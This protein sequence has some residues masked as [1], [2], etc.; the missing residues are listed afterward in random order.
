LF[1]SQNENQFL[2]AANDQSEPDVIKFSFYLIDASKGIFVTYLNSFSKQLDL[3]S[4]G[5]NDGKYFFH[6]SLCDDETIYNK[7]YSFD[8]AANELLEFIAIDDL[9][10]KKEHTHSNMQFDSFLAEMVEQTANDSL[11][12]NDV[13]DFFS[14][15]LTTL[16]NEFQILMLQQIYFLEK[17][18]ILFLAYAQMVLVIDVESKKLV[19]Q[20]KHNFISGI[21]C[22]EENDLLLIFTCNGVVCYKLSDLIG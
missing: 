10:P 4:Y 11:E 20:I 2:F 19:N 22:F 5:F 6:G 7:I 13:E 15:L 12:E 16:N 3:T 17:C 8:I 21:A 1:Q 9:L 14:T 18:N